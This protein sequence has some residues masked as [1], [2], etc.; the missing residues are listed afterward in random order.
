MVW[1]LCSF[2]CFWSHSFGLFSIPAII[3]VAVPLGIIGVI[4]IL[5]LTG[6]T[7][8]IQ[9]YLGTIFM[10]GIAVSNSVLLVDFANRRRAD[11][12]AALGA[13]TPVYDGGMRKARIREAQAELTAEAAR[14]D[15]LRE[16]I[17]REVNDVL[18][19]S[20]SATAALASARQEQRLAGEELG[21]V[22]AQAKVGL[23]SA[24]SRERARL[25][26][27]AELSSRTMAAQLAD[28]MLR[29]N[30][31]FALGQEIHPRT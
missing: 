27:L 2:T 26:L 20:S 23:V 28:E 10:V 8:N 24:A 15:Q 1:P 6:T 25:H 13:S 19:Q 22:S 9:S 12:V 4:A 3:L 14:R 11:G 16:N 29:I 5:L 18:L 17:A 7:L 30:L 31:A 21:G